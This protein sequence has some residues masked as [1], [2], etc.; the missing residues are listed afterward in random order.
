ML[1]T[2]WGGEKRIVSCMIDLNCLAG[3]FFI[4]FIIFTNFVGF[5]ALK[6]W[7]VKPLHN[8]RKASQS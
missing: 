1:I 2:L 4:F 8:S 5:V 7:N 3:I 6:K